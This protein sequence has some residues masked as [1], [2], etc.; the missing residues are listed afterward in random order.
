M[1]ETDYSQQLNELLRTRPSKVQLPSGFGDI[2]RRRGNLPSSVRDQRAYVRRYFPGRAILEFKNTD[3]VIP[4]PDGFE[5]V[6]TRDISRSGLGLLCHC[7]LYPGERP[8]IWLPTGR[9]LCEVARC[10]RRGPW[11]FEVGVV[12]TRVV[13]D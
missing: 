8:I 10:A 3:Q 11:C 5:A 12:F 1:L 6:F 13:Q 2:L 7:E 4:R 9:I